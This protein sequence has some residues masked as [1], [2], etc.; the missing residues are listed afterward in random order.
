MENQTQRITDMRKEHTKDVEAFDGWL[1][2][3]I[4]MKHKPS[5]RKDHS[6]T[7]DELWVDFE[8]CFDA[9]KG[10]LHYKPFFEAYHWQLMQ[11]FHGDGVYYLE[12]RM[13]LPKLFD[14][15]GKELGQPEVLSLLHRIVE[16][17]RLQHPAFH[18]VKVILAKHKN[19]ND[20]ELE[21]ALKLYD[22]LRYF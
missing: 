20:Q 8:S 11:E 7:V 13:A 6:A 15:D 17:F 22:A 14:T 19:M 4:N 9:M 12:L 16:E 2:S 21:N 1:D 18:G 5:A 3:I 10:F